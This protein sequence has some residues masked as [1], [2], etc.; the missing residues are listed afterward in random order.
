[1]NFF[2]C[3][4]LETVIIEEGVKTIGESAFESCSSLKSIYFYGE[5]LPTVPPSA[6]LGVSAASVMT[7]EAY[8]NEIFG[9]LNVSKGTTINECLQPTLTFT[10]SSIFTQSN[11]FTKSFAFKESSSFT[12]SSTFT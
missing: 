8:Q 6:F 3:S 10:E 11:T 1:M 5:T 7:L 2:S 12:E 4:A 9:E